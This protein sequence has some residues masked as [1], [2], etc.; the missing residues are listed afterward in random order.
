LCFNKILLNNHVFYSIIPSR[1]WLSRLYVLYLHWVADVGASSI[2][3]TSWS[4]W[5]L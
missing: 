1:K 4:V 2:T 5:K 3:I